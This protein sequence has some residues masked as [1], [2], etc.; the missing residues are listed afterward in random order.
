M[1]EPAIVPPPQPSLPPAP[2][3]KQAKKALHKLFLTLF[4]RGRSSRGLRKQ[5]APQSVGSKLALVLFLYAAVGMSSF[6][7][8]R[9]PVFALSLYLHATTLFFLG[10]FVAAS[11]GEVLFNKEEADILLHRPVAPQTLLWAKIG[12]LV[13]V[14]L[15]LAGA[16][17]LAGFFAGMG[18]S[19]GGWLYPVAHLLS[20]VLEALFCAGGVVTVYQLCLRWFGR[21]RLDSL[22]TLAQVMV[23]IAAVL[24]G[25]IPQL[26]TRFHGKI[27]FNAHSWWVCLLPP[28]W[29]AGLDD[30]IAGSRSISSGILAAVGMIVTAVILW[31]AFQKLAT[32]YEMGLQSI[33][34]ATTA[35]RPKGEAG[36]RLLDKLASRAPLRWWLR[37]PVSRAAFLLVAAYLMRDRDV[38]LR[39]YPGLAPMLIWPIIM[40]VQD[41]GQVQAAGPSPLSGM[42]VAF[43]GIF[44]G[45]IP[46]LA[47]DLLR[48]SQQ[49]QAA[50]LFRVAPV[51]GPGPFCDGTRRAVLLILTLPVLVGV[52]ALVCLFGSANAHL[53]LLL[54]GII[55]LP[56]YAMLACLKGNAVPFSLPSEEA[57]SA[58]RGLKMIGAMMASGVLAVAATLC[59][60]YGFFTWLLLAEVFVAL[61]LYLPMRAS[62]ASSRW[63]SLE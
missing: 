13:R 14:S 18:A 33:G 15:W 7:F 35:K 40:L 62:V 59:W 60:N 1:S 38:K 31:L 30:L 45:I 32:D 43:T 4:L 44:V 17:N 3:S 9:Q 19:D 46:L 8:V 51:E 39:V 27:A 20:T 48:F 41:R 37:D 57:K 36:R 23:G 21:E 49:W 12:V 56:V 47:V 24:G 52:I 28:A 53:P 63:T 61:G 34:E 2:S 55:A 26:L 54:P 42:T 58:S 5:G 6:A 10:M 50:D 11:S 22:M 16:F 29:F 25:Q